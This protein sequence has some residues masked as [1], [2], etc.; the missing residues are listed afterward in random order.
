MKIAILGTRGIPNNYGGFEQ[1]AEFL[2]LGL[3]KKGYE[4]I[5]YNSHNH[6]YQ[7]SNWNGV[8]LVHCYDPEFKLG[9]AGQFIYDLN[10]IRD[11][12]SRDVDVVLQLGYTSSSIWGWLLPKNV[13][14]TTNMDGL[15]W[16][17]TKYSSKVRKF[18]LWAERL[19]VK[20]SDH[21]ISDSV[22]IQDYLKDKYGK[23]STFIPYGAYV[24]D[25]PDSKVLDEY[26]ITEYE[27]DLLIARLE[28]ENSIEVILDGVSQAKTGRPFLVIGKHETKYG[29]YLKLKY[30]SDES[31][32]FVG[33]IYDITKLNSIRYY[34]NIYFHGHTVGGTNPSLLEAMASNS[35][36]CANLNPFNQ[37][38]LGKDAVYFSNSEEVSKVLTSIFKQDLFCKE[39][40]LNNTNK[41]HNVYNWDIIVQQYADHLQSIKGIIT[42]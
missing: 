6:P 29:E 14:V 4:V 33:G 28:P 24:S 20:Y 38:I 18:L 34:S 42:R 31:I 25:T 41:I 9:T 3:V 2:A 21:L 13:V 7:E 36:I 26:K 16:K 32:R 8:E 30:S 19:G 37:Y 11:L 35:L 40:I 27:Y 39:M 17:R 22:G 12:K 23:E 5:V 15:E 10:C 1:C